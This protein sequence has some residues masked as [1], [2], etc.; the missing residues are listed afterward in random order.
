MK[1]LIRKFKG[2]EPVIKAYGITEIFEHNNELYITSNFDL[3]EHIREMFEQKLN[4]LV[5][6]KF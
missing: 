2:L 5:S 1:N 3:P 4:S 6:A